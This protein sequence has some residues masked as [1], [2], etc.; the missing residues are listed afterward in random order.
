MNNSTRISISHELLH[1]IFQRILSGEVSILFEEGGAK[2]KT[3]VHE[4]SRIYNLP[5]FASVSS[6]RDV[7]TFYFGD[8]NYDG[9]LYD[10]FSPAIVKE[11]I[12]E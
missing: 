1:D 5:A 6:D 7:T 8:G 4:A 2:Y 11:E 9:V 10:S 3:F 12:K